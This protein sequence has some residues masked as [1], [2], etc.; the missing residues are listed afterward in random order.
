MFPITLFL[1]DVL[2]K[3]AG[4]HRQV[5]FDVEN[6]EEDTQKA[7][8]DA[9]LQKLSGVGYDG[10]RE[11]ERRSYGYKALAKGHI[12]EDG[13]I[14]KPAELLEQYTADEEGLIAVND[15]AADATEI[16]QER[17]QLEPP[18]VAGKLVHEPPGLDGLVRLHLVQPMNSPDDQEVSEGLDRFI[19]SRE[20]DGHQ[21]SSH[22]RIRPYLD[23]LM[24]FF[25]CPL[26]IS[27]AFP[28]S[29]L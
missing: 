15:P 21:P 26:R 16:V 2:E 27:K 7:T 19:Q 4:Q 20:E 6:D 8:P 1:S 22:R 28:C 9:H 18:I 24:P 11:Q 12:F 10:R 23:R 17:D 3:G 25:F 13:P 29:R 14:G 5:E